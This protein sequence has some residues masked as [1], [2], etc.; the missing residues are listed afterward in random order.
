[1]FDTETKDM[2]AAAGYSLLKQNGALYVFGNNETVKF[3]F[4]AL[5]YSKYM[6]SDIMT[7]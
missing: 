6:F 2:L 1:M 4:C 5:P 7:F 3:D